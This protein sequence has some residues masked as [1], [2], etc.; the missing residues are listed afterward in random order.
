MQEM[1]F[2]PL[3]Q[4]ENL[5]CS[6]NRVLYLFEQNL[7]FQT[8]FKGSESRQASTT[9]PPNSCKL[10]QPGQPRHGGNRGL[11]EMV[12]QTYSYCSALKKDIRLHTRKANHVW[13][14]LSKTFWDS[15]ARLSFD[16][17]STKKSWV[18]LSRYYSNINSARPI[19]SSTAQ[20]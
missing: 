15:S 8:S 16:Y 7:I 10:P 11:G 1:Q 14:W 3:V 9:F 5:A 2:L 12:K 18:Y 13:L 4:L 6:V 17:K 19:V 20:F